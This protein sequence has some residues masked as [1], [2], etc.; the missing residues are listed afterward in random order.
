M[1]HQGPCGERQKETGGGEVVT[2]FDH[3]YF[4]RIHVIIY[5]YWETI[6]FQARTFFGLFSA[7]IMYLLQS[8]RQLVTLVIK[9]HGFSHNEAKWTSIHPSILF[10]LK[11]ANECSYG[12]S[13]YS[14][15][16]YSRC[17]HT[18]IIPSHHSW[19]FSFSKCFPQSESDAILH[20][21]MN[22]TQ[23]QTIA[24]SPFV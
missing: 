3:N 9:S 13:T 12:I 17:F 20:S 6:Y 8:Q 4:Q 21:W 2:P 24:T 18:H 16:Q 15:E 11:Y 23:S 22:F 1:G 10:S 7:F 14:S 5:F 19:L